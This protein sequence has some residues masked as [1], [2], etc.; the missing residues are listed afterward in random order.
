MFSLRQKL[1]IKLKFCFRK[2]SCF[3]ADLSILPPS[4][5]ISLLQKIPLENSLK[6]NRKIMGCQCKVEIGDYLL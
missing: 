2:F 1:N 4:S 5:D 3:S 6:V